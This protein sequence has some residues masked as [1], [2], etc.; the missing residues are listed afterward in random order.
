MGKE[1]GHY[2]DTMITITV[3]E[4]IRHEHWARITGHRQ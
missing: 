3:I 2:C 1:Y 4:Q